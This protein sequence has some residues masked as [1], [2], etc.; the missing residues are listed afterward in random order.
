MFKWDSLPFFYKVSRAISAFGLITVVGAMIYAGV[1]K[2]VP[3]LLL[4][5]FG[6]LCCFCFGI[7]LSVTPEDKAM[8]EK[9]ER[10]LVAV[11]NKFKGVEETA[12]ALAAERDGLATQVEAH[13][14]SLTEAEKRVEELSKTLE[15]LKVK[16]APKAAPTPDKEPEASKELPKPKPEA[17]KPAKDEKKEPEIINRKG[18]APTPPPAE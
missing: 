17:N 6:M 11:L 15:S 12:R 1:Y 18:S 3:S 13:K 16:P 2:V 4:I 5:G 14:V 9:V 8:L 10:D 7:G